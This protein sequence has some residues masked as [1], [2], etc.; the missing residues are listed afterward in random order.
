M[1]IILVNPQAFLI[2]R[3][4]LLLP[5][6]QQAAEGQATVLI[7]SSEADAREQLDHQ[8]LVERPIDELI[9][10]GGDGTFNLALNWAL[11]LPKHLRPPA[12]MPVGGGQICYMT[13]FL[14]MR[15][16]DPL[17]NLEDF[18]F[19]RRLPV[20]VPWRPL[21]ISEQGVRDV[22]HAAVFATGIVH[23]FIRWYDALG[24]GSMLV[25][26]LLV[27]L[28]V[29]LVLS[30]R[31]RAWH[32]RLEGS[33]GEVRIGFFTIPADAYIGLV[34]STIPVMIPGCWPFAGEL[35]QGEFYSIA[36]WGTLRRLAAGLPWVWTGK[37]V[38]F[39]QDLLYNGP[40]GRVS[41]NTN[42]AGYI[43]DGD[44]AE[45]SRTELI[46]EHRHS[47]DVRLGP[48]VRLIGFLP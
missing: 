11:S 17:G 23:R 16:R 40:V 24:K 21:A 37:S 18:L 2:R 10:V 42:D 20:A 1:R 28:A 44:L 38:S 12:L 41:L 19:S 9:I 45:F 31:I 27:A 5:R 6:I 15:R 43:A 13:V 26:L 30:D 39:L 25:V 36:Y 34:A 35:Q 33:S 7:P 8:H 48:E 14:G 22:R 29:P 46:R 47:V 3:D 32:G 4:P